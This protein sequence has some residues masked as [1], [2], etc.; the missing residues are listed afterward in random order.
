MDTQSAESNAPALRLRRP[1]PNVSPSTR[2]DSEK[3]KNSAGIT[4]EV[5]TAL[6]V[7]THNKL[8]TREE[9]GSVFM[10]SIASLHQSL[11]HRQ[12]LAN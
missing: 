8:T 10:T 11:R 9:D 4:F 1:S 3:A 12:T 2:S 7:V 5:A 6:D